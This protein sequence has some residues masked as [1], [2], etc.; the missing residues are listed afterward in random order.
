[1]GVNIIRK[2]DDYALP[3]LEKTDYSSLPLKDE[4]F[5]DKGTLGIQGAPT[6]FLID[7]EGNIVFK[8]FIISQDNEKMLELMINE[9]V[10]RKRNQS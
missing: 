7:H 6:N 9:L 2:Q 4:P 1:M 3:F 5:K 8:N 10:N